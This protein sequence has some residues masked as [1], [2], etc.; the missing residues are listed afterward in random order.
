MFDVNY[1]K[2]NKNLKRR[3]WTNRFNFNSILILYIAIKRIIHK[4]IDFKFYKWNSRCSRSFSKPRN[5]NKTICIDRPCSYNGSLPVPQSAEEL[6]RL[7]LWTIHLLNWLSFVYIYLST[8]RLICCRLSFDNE[9]SYWYTDR[10]SWLPPPIN[11]CNM[12][13]R[14]PILI[15][16]LRRRPWDT[17]SWLRCTILHAV[18]KSRYFSALEMSKAMAYSHF[19]RL[20]PCHQPDSRSRFRKYFTT[21]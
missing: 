4:Y 19:M 8:E 1:E 10:L 11:I 2:A 3:T 20:K 14:F 9:T 18:T 17:R 13:Y 16:Y 5:E 6:L 15:S 7:R 12:K 21:T